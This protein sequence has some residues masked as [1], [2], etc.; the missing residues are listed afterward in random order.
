MYF[1]KNKRGDNMMNIFK[2]KKIF[3]LLIC[4]LISI[5]LEACGNLFPMNEYDYESY[6]YGLPLFPLYPINYSSIYDNPP[7]F[8]WSTAQNFTNYHLQL[9]NEYNFSGDL[10]I[11]DDTLTAPG[12]VMTDTIP[13]N[14]TY[15]WRVRIKNTQDKW[16]DWGTPWE[17]DLL[18]PSPTPYRAPAPTPD[19]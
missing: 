14:T 19:P 8:L 6:Y 15:Y 12:Y 11:D 13:V 18:P 17:F 1:L 10:I 7:Y 4:I 9:G 5:T 16:L 2:G 3:I